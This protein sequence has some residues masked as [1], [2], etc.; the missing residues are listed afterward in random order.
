MIMKIKFFLAAAGVALI[1]SCK[2][3]ST[4]RATDASVTVSSSAA[5]TAFTTDYPNATAVV[6]GYYDPAVMS[7]MDWR[8]VGW[9]PLD[10][11]DRLVHFNL[12]NQNYYVL[13][14][15]TG[16]RIA[17][18]SV[19]SD[20]SVLPSAARDQLSILYPAYNITGLNRVTLN[21]RNNAMGYEVE[22]K[23]LYY[24]AHVLVDD[25]GKVLDTRVVV[26]DQPQL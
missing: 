16:T 4:Y 22:L 10:P 13:Y 23:K 3:S 7:P 11:S 21:H 6:W 25:N 12:D 24:T 20:Y 26:S 2:T 17:S 5:E 14:D 8:L 19:L 18:A 1:A 9:E 15:E